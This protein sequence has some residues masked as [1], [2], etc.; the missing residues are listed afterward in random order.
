MPEW[1]IVVAWI[2]L[3][4]GIL[5]SPVVL[6]DLFTGHPQHMAIMNVVWVI[7]PLY[8]GPLALWA[9]FKYGRLSSHPAMMR[10]KSQG[11]PP[12]SESKPDA[13]AYALAATHCGA[14]CTLGDLI[15]EWGIF[16]FPGILA[17]FGYRTLWN[18]PIFSAW[19]IDFIVAFL[20]GIVFQYFTIVPMQNLSPGKGI[21]AAVKAD[22]LS[23]TAWQVGM[24]GWMAIATF[25]IFGHEIPK[26]SPV[27]WFMMQI[28]MLLGFATAYPVNVWLVKRGIKEKM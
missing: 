28:A 5:S 17:Y 1:L 16:A 14:G 3:G 12:P 8:A 20:L 7:T 21:L 2:S 15:A 24:Y 13:A 27:F 10:A 6:V 22:T 26:D 4:I 23:L 9:Y 25:A 18:V 19:I 11:E